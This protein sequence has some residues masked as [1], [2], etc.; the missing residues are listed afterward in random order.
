LNGTHQL[1]VSP[2]NVNL[3]GENA[4]VTHKSTKALSDASKEAGL[5]LNAEKTK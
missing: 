2:D 4:N 3:L 1:L 5:E